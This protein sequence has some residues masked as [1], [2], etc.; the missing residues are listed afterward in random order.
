[1][2]LD[3]VELVLGWEEAFGIEIPDEAATTMRKPRD[4]V[5]YLAGKLGAKL[6]PACETQSGFYRVRA[7]VRGLWSVPRAQIRPSTPVD[8]VLPRQNRRAEWE[9]LGSEL[10]VAAWPTLTRS[11]RTFRV[12]AGIVLAASGGA[13]LLAV[14]QV[15]LG[16]WV[17]PALVLAS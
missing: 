13:W 17:A 16:G 1:M 12:L 9:R 7:A 10:G 14:Y 5:D 2:G 15:G 11:D 8:V 6:S 4:V 3:G